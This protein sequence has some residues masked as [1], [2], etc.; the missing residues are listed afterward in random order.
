MSDETSRPQSQDPPPHGRPR[1]L[2]WA[3]AI[4]GVIAWAL[5]PGAGSPRRGLAVAPP[6]AADSPPT[7]LFDSRL[8]SLRRGSMSWELRQ[9]PRR[10]VVDQVC[11]VPDVATFL[12]VV[13]S[14]DSETYYPVLIYDVETT[15][16][17]LRAFRPAKVIRYNRKV[18]PVPEDRLWD[19]AVFS[20]GA[21]WSDEAAAVG[22]ILPGDKVPKKLGPTPPGVVIS[23]PDSP[24][25]AGAVAL[26]AGRFQPLVRLDSGK[27]FDDVL[28][29]K[30]LVQFLDG[31]NKAVAAVVP[32]HD[33]MGDDCDFL[34][35]A[36]DAPYSYEDGDGRNALDD[37]IGRS[38]DS[39]VRWAYVGRLMGDP[40][41]SAYR[42]MCSLFLQPQSGAFF[43]GYEGKGEVFSQYATLPATLQLGGKLPV[44]QVGGKPRADLASW[45][46]TFDPKNRHG[47]VMINTSGSPT[48]FNLPQG[49]GYYVDVPPSVPAAVHMIHSFSAADPRNPDTIAGRWLA[50]GAFVYFGSMNEPFL[51]SFRTPSLIASL[52]AERIPLSA[53]FRNAPREGVFGKPWRLVY[54]GDPLYRIEFDPTPPA[55]L[56]TYPPTDH[57]PRFEEYARPAADASADTRFVW[58]LQT[59]IFRL[60][61]GQSSRQSDDLAA[62]LLAI[63]RSQVSPNFRPMFDALTIDQAY[64]SGK[65][66]ELRDWIGRIPAA[67]QTGMIP[68]YLGSTLLAELN[69][70]LGMGNPARAREVWTALI[71][72]SLP[73]EVKVLSTE[74][75]AATATTPARRSD[76]RNWLR[77]SLRPDEPADS[78]RIINE[79]MKRIDRVT[80]EERAKSKPAGR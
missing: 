76:W 54:F 58:A 46:A 14:W 38:A 63:P 57:W 12:E 11:L 73:Q 4:L 67:E 41:L 40:V 48:Q 16:K 3:L 59:A 77:A 6:Q 26:A 53:A 61:R 31:V 70:A 19:L 79:E 71:R 5:V 15:L 7:G 49:T 56:K 17:F 44:T 42:A 80:Q 23:S 69:T 30:D 2:A 21:A 52:L 20:V 64:E 33:A 43:D 72:S 28:Q 32:A 78:G 29:G 34:T 68:R 27:K 18:P 62:I 60:Q 66:A 39:T 22:E 36:L 75:I 51:Q 37:R 9:G 25:L 55:R 74:R 8:E 10:K 47:L 24:S 35:L 50:N 45:H 1:P 13:A 65:Y